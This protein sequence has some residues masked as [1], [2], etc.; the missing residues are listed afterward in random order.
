MIVTTYL[1]RCNGCGTLAD[2][3][4]HHETEEDA[5]S[6]AR[7]GGFVRCIMPVQPTGIPGRSLRYIRPVLSVGQVR[8]WLHGLYDLLQ[9]SPR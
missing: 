4:H 7:E 5:L 8:P 2:S 9:P 1:V 6:G 3:G